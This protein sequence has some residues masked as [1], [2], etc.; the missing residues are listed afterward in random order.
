MASE[1]TKVGWK[2]K[3][4]SPFAKVEPG[5]AGVAL[6]MTLT[7]F[8]I[9][10]AYYVL[11][12]AREQLLLPTTLFG[13]PGPELKSYAG[14]AMALVFMGILPLYGR[15]ANQVGRLRLINICYSIV[16]ACLVAFF[17][18]A[19]LGVPQLGLAFFIWIGLINMFLV[20]QFWS[21]ANDI[22]SEDQGKRLFAIIAVGGSL[23]AILGPKV[24]E[25]VSVYSGML[26][27]AGIL[28]ACIVLFNVIDK[29]DTDRPGEAEKSK[30]P[31]GGADGF[32]LVLSNRYLLLIALMVLL[33]NFVNTT[34]EFLLSHAAAEHAKEVV[35]A[36]AAT[37]QLTGDA[38]DK[39]VGKEIGKFYSD[40][41]FWVNLIGFIV[42]AFI[43]SRVLK[44][45]GVRVALFVLPLIAFAGYAGFAIIGGL[46]VIRIC[47]IGENSA[48]Y[49]IQN[50]VRQALWL[51]TS[52]E[53]KYKAKAAIDTFFL[54][55]GDAFS[56]FFIL[57]FVHT[58]HVSVQVVA[59][60]NVGVVAVWIAIVVGIAREHKRLEAKGVPEAKA[61][62]KNPKGSPGRLAEA[63]T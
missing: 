28:A 46:A 17:V 23:G 39:A 60:I 13:I 6:L 2:E 58:L 1:G 52:R 47:K 22:Y 41:Y 42:Q 14:A 20:A 59:A 11:K 9:L 40:L 37:A 49:S 48:D 34:G 50:T 12:P 4:L 24:A 43:V 16:L 10:C 35:H 8:L 7:V 3:V 57:L 33:A 18:M 25:L 61:T 26:M 62:E 32:K 63:T 19:Q 54:R 29:L 44:W 51:P 31:V 15:L 45:F 27:A 36:A 38:F 5:E 30:V 21:Y 53:E 55:L 56:G